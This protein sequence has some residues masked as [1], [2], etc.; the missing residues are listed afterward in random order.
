M[1]KPT[2]V[3]TIMKEDIGYSAYTF[4][5]PFLYSISKMCIRDSATG[6]LAQPDCS[7]YP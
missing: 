3:M 5:K 7:G 2:L 6:V 1:K 4:V